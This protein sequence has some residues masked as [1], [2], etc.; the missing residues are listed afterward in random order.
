MSAEVP[1]RV[2]IADDDAF[3]RRM[4]KGALQAAGM[5]VVAEAKNGHEAVELGLHYRPDVL[6]MDVVMPG[7]DGILATRRILKANPDQLVVMLTG[8]GEDEIGLLALSTG[9]VGLLSKEDN[10]NVAPR[11]RE[12]VR[13]GKG[14]VAS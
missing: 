2:I 14:A 11:T 12:G 4:I 10:N 13:R 7:L 6:V 8:G 9:A 3:A 1:L 5:T